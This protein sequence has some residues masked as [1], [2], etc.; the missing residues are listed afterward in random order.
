MCIN[1]ARAFM[2]YLIICLVICTRVECDMQARKGG[3]FEMA[4]RR[5]QKYRAT[6]AGAAEKK[7]GARCC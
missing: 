7:R 2:K 3:K 5:S 4:C 1:W 6:K